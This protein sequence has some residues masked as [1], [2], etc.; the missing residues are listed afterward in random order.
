MAPKMI[1]KGKVERG[2]AIQLETPADNPPHRS[3]GADAYLQAMMEA[4]KRGEVVDW[5]GVA[6]VLR[7]SVDNIT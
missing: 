3:K 6:D 4:S 1:A 5:D 2:G 7:F